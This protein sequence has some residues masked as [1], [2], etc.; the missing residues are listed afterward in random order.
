MIKNRYLLGVFFILLSA[1]GFSTLQMIVKLLPDVSVGNKMFF[2]NIVITIITFI[3]IKM[4]GISLKVDKKDIPL[5][6]LRVICGTLGVIISFYTLMYIPLADSTIIQ[7]LSSFIMLILSY[8]FFKEKFTS[9]HFIGLFIAFIGVIFIVKPGSSSFS[10]GYILAMLGACCTALA[11]ISIRGL[12]IRGNINPF[13]IVFYFSFISCVIFIPEL[14]INTP[15]LDLKTLILLLSIGIFGSIGQYG[16]TFAYKFASS[17]EV[18][19]FEYTQV[20]F[21]SILGIVFLNEIPDIYSVI[22]YVIITITGIYMFNY[23][24]K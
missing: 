3:V 6:S 7:K 13:T 24:K 12:G 5:L 15:S 21:S 22:G 14:I 10:F 8:I 17:R 4:E 2:R 20:I 16:I 11:Y 9:I 1:I 18:G 19:V 23:N